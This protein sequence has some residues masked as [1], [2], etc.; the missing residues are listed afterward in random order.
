MSNPIN[1]K[2]FL[3]TAPQDFGTY[4][5][6]VSYEEGVNKIEYFPYEVAAHKRVLMKDS[7][8]FTYPFKSEDRSFFASSLKNSNADDVIFLRNGF[9]T[10]AT[11]SNLA[12][13]DGKYWYTPET[14]FL[15]GVKRQFL[16]NQGILKER[17]MSESDLNKFQ[18]IAFIN[19]M[20]DFEFSYFFELIDDKIELTLVE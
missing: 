20:R 7:G 1:L 6:R 14:Y 16:I 13:Y 3:E 19:A 11:Y 2:V 8:D 10:D 17:S 12:F 5:C 9:L 15:N 4:R 18:K